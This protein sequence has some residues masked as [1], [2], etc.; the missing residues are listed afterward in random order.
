MA[1]AADLARQVSE[2]LFKASCDLPLAFVVMASME[3]GRG[4]G[5]TL[6]TCIAGARAG[7]N[8]EQQ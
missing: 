1:S 3:F 6:V 2:I 5:A 8:P 4:S 7:D